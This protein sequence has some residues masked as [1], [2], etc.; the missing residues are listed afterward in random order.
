MCGLC[1]VTEEENGAQ[2]GEGAGPSLR[3][4]K[5]A[6]GSNRQHDMWA[7]SWTFNFTVSY[8]VCRGMSRSNESSVLL[9]S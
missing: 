1:P 3:L 6:A 8:T 4:E 9:Q 5:K 2:P 7:K